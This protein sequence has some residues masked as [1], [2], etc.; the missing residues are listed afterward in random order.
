[1]LYFILLNKIT[2]IILRTW[3]K[4]SQVMICTILKEIRKKPSR[5]ILM[6]F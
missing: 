3:F 1:M 2:N 6:E 5:A 4:P